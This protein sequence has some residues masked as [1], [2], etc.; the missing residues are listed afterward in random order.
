VKNT[1][2]IYL[3]LD[4][5]GTVKLARQPSLEMGK[6]KKILEVKI[7]VVIVTVVVE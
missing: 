1:G 4:I 6:L 7:N 5:S 3:K 2:S